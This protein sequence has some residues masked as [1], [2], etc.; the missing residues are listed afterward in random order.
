M[1]THIGL[2]EIKATDVK[3]THDGP[4]TDLQLTDSQLT[5]S[6]INS[7]TTDYDGITADLRQTCNGPTADS[8]PTRDSQRTHSGLGAFPMN[9]RRTHFGSAA[10]SNSTHESS[11]RGRPRACAP[12]PQILRTS[13]AWDHGAQA[14]W[15]HGAQ[16]AWG[17]GA[18]DLKLFSF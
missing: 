9:W 8:Q 11:A 12:W 10:V 16:A 2:R 14:T 7:L 6:T 17:H 1:V 15:G 5:H 18:Q 13:S 3:R 4:T